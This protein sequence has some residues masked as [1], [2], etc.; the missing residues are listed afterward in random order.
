MNGQLRD[1]NALDLD[2]LIT[3]SD[4][5][6][7][8]PNSIHYRSPFER[9]DSEEGE[10]HGTVSESDAVTRPQEANSENSSVGLMEHSKDA[11]NSLQGGETNLPQSESNSSM[12]VENGLDASV[13]SVKTSVKTAASPASRE[14]LVG[15]HSPVRWPLFPEQ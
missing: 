3:T 9:S 6:H 12:R 11:S 14:A 2:G 4:R 10:G 13:S 5:S 7:C 8:N 1:A 15:T